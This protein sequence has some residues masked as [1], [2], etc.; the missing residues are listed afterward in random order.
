M[1]INLLQYVVFKFINMEDDDE[2]EEDAL[3][4]VGLT[5]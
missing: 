4:E 2:E 5:K 1:N 3:F